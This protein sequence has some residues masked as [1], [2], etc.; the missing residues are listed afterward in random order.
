M[1][2]GKSIVEFADGD[3]SSAIKGIWNRVEHHLKNRS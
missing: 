3:V 1:V 2:A